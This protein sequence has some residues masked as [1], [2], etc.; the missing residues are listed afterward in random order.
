MEPKG[1]REGRHPVVV[2]RCTPPHWPNFPP[3]LTPCTRHGF[4]TGISCPL[5]RPGAELLF[6]AFGQ[7]YDLV[8]TTLPFYEWIEVFG[9]E[10]LTSAL[11]D[12]LTHQVHIREMKGESYRLK[13]SRENAASPASEE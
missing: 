13:L 10:H 12:R 8:S 5:S 11:L 7:R 4:S 6:V 9:S 3:P 2:R 1:A